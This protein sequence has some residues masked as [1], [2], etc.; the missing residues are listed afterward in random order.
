M[1]KSLLY[2]I[3]LAFATP[4]YAATS[5][6]TLVIEQHRFHPTEISIPANERIKLIIDN[7][8]ATAEEF[9]SHDLKREKIIPGHT[10]ASVWIGP[11]AKA[12]I[13]SLVNFTRIPLK[14]PL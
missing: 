5:E 8:D 2:M 10:K 1:N 13:D 12:A 3:L 6:Y 7:R 9:E 4:I 11:C 14:V